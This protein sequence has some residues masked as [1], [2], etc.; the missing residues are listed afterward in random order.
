ME[1]IEGGIPERSLKLTPPFQHAMADLC[2]PFLIYTSGRSVATRKTDTKIKAYVLALVC[3]STKAIAFTALQSL[4]TDHLILGLMRMASRYGQISSLTMDLG[5][6]FVSA[7]K[8]QDQENNWEDLNLSPEQAKNLQRDLLGWGRKQKLEFH[9]GTPYAHH[10]Q[11]L[12]EVTIR[13]LKKLLQVFP[14]KKLDI[15][16]FDTLVQAAASHLND[17][18]LSLHLGV[19]HFISPNDILHFNLSRKDNLITYQVNPSNLTDLSQ[20][21]SQLLNRFH[22]NFLETLKNKIIKT[23]KWKKLRPGMLPGDVVLVLDHQ[24]IKKGRFGLATVKE[25]YPDD[26]GIVRTVLVQY[27]IPGKNRFRTTERHVSSLSLILEKEQVEAGVTSLE[28]VL[29]QPEPVQLSLDDLADDEELAVPDPDQVPEPGDSAA[30]DKDA[31]AEVDR[32]L[33]TL[34]T[35]NSP[36]PLPTPF[37]L[38]WIPSRTRCCWTRR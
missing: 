23:R 30:G 2:G 3:M 4:S 20:E 34:Y 13:E 17:R 19:G 24:R 22:K 27:K 18:P 1:Q 10:K 37:P 31:E 8:I 11:G 12:V 9:F 36:A 35:L 26:E 7:A 14:T 16:D 28:D 38:T 33:E 29:L 21:A 15:L 32:L 5:T 25:I 6:N